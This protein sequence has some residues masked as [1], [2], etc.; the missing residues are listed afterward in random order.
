M[1]TNGDR[2]RGNNDKKVMTLI[3]NDPII[4]L[5]PPL[6]YKIYYLKLY[7]VPFISKSTAKRRPESIIT[8]F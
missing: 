7:W 1:M 3:V 4:I 2:G 8:N 6:Y 5:P